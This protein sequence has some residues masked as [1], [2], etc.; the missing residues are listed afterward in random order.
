VELD[1][2][3]H[4]ELGRGDVIQRAARFATHWKDTVA[5]LPYPV[6][7]VDMRYPNGFAVRMPGY[8][9]PQAAQGKK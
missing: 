2:S 5:R 9:D 4:I 1:N 3:V 8:Q 6:S 7:Y